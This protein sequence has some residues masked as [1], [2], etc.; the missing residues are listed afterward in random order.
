[1]DTNQPEPMPS[2]TSLAEL[3]VEN[4]LPAYLRPFR[5]GELCPNCELGRLDY[6]GLLDLECPECGYSQGSGGGCT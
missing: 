5:R 1:M 3:P 4:S 6:N 2:Q